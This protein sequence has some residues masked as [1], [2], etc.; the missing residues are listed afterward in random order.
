M[1]NTFKKGDKIRCV[2]ASGWGGITVGKEYDVVGMTSSG[3]CVDLLKDDG[4]KSG[5]RPYANRFELVKDK[6]KFKVGDK[7]RNLADHWPE[8]T[9]GAVYTITRVR[10]NAREL[11]PASSG[12]S[13]QLAELMGKH[14]L[15]HRGESD[16]EL[17]KDEPQGVEQNISTEFEIRWHRV[18]A[19]T[20]G[21][22][23]SGRVISRRPTQKLAEDFV[24]MNAGNYADGEFS[25]TQ[26]TVLKRVQ[27]VRRVKRVTKTVHELVDA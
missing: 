10:D 18:G 8:M 15:H 22:P 17:V 9:V 3:V 7:V 20:V 27:Q 11:G 24:E 25:I 26:V 1:N 2:N 6:P 23:M 19:R 5:N 14:P 13:I 12:F 21:S 4:G 16:F